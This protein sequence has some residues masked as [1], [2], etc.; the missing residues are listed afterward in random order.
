M[1]KLNSLEEPE[2]ADIS[3]SSI[4]YMRNSDQVYRTNNFP[5]HP[6]SSHSCKNKHK[7][8]NSDGFKLL[9]DNQRET[10]LFKR[11]SYR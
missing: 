9:D 10:A 11:N 3:D 8:N 1:P 7:D 4:E 2:M 6:S 5:P